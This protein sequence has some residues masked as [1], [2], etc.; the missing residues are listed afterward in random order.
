MEALRAMM[1]VYSYLYHGVLSLF[2]IG[3][4]GLALLTDTSLKLD[5]MPWS[6]KT[7]PLWLFGTALGGLIIVVLAAAGKLRPLFLLWALAVLVLMVRGYFLS[8]YNFGG[9]QGLRTA[10]LLTAGC[11]LA[12]VGAWYCV[13]QPRLKRV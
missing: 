9:T 4:S 7:L 1:R 12:V 2:L 3:V 6:G 13:R 11:M 5:M 8:P 10:L